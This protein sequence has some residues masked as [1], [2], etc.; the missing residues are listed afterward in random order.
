MS[1]RATAAAAPGQH[2]SVR[3]LRDHWASIGGGLLWFVFLINFNVFGPADGDSRVQYQFVQRLF[4]DAPHALGYYFGLGLIEAPFY[5]LGKL[6]DELGIHT[7]STGTAESASV[8]VGLSALTLLAWPLLLPVFRGLRLR[9]GAFAILAAGFGTPLFYYASFVVGKNHPIDAILFTAVVYLVFRYLRTNGDERWVPF[10]LG[11]VFG[12]S[13]TVRYFDGAEAVALVA[14]LLL[15]RR[16]GDAARVALTSAVVCGV[17]FVIPAAYGIPVF[18]GQ[19]YS[20]DKVL[21]F[22]PLNPLRMLF[23]DHRGLYVW[24][25]ISVLATIGLVLLFRRRPEHRRFLVAITAMSVALMES[26]SLIAFWDGT[27]SFGQ[28]FFT[29]LFPVI[30]IGLAGLLEA[31]PRVTYA[32]A[33]LAVAWSLFLA[34]NLTIIGGPQY[35]EDTP[36]G[37]EDL[38]LV[39]VRTHTTPGAYLWGIWHRSRLLH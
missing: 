35:L 37:V 24:S 10:A 11:A 2:A 5:A 16:L 39:P 28:R 15:W 34:F 27:S 26:Y 36:G 29:P 12:L 8:A 7:I 14:L 19:N 30:A 3:F 18:S 21:V 23:T 22:A 6:L 17:L 1:V 25:P 31:A 13:Y 38:A 32:A 4:G 33:T 20:P 9:R